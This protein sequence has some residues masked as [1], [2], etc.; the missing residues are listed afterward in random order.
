M[1]WFGL[2]RWFLFYGR[3]LYGS[4]LIIFLTFRLISILIFWEFSRSQSF[5]PNWVGS[6]VNTED[7]SWINFLFSGELFVLFVTFFQTLIVS[8]FISS[9]IFLISI[10]F[11]FILLLYNFIFDILLWFIWNFTILFCDF[12]GNGIGLI[13]ILFFK[14]LIFSSR[15]WIKLWLKLDSW[16]VLFFIFLFM[17][18][19]FE[20]FFGLI[21]MESHFTDCVR[22][23]LIFIIWIFHIMPIL[24]VLLLRSQFLFFQLYFFLQLFCFF[25]F[26]LF[27]SLCLSLLFSCLYFLFC[28]RKNGFLGWNFLINWFLLFFHF[29]FLLRYLLLLF[30]LEI[31]FNRLIFLYFDEFL[32]KFL[33][34]F[35]WW[36]LQFF[37]RLNF[38]LTVNGLICWFDNFQKF[39]ELFDT[40][41][42]SSFRRVEIFWNSSENFGNKSVWTI[43]IN[44]FH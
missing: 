44:F 25:F 8:W 31:L 17:C 21:S 13:F 11:V 37:E 9:V 36:F 28:Y 41:L 43:F 1:F 5:S 27:N 34:Y 20:I 33:L 12:I 23:F 4:S 2:L 6:T 40:F 32:F 39:F 18:L 15:S 30:W 19:I 42:S 10:F 22:N 29:R 3:G 14:F 24:R 35:L 7:N 26:G 16:I 38:L